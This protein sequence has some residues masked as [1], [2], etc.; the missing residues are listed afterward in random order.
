LFVLGIYV[1]TYMLGS[2]PA[3]TGQAPG[4]SLCSG[5]MWK[6]LHGTWGG[7][8]ALMHRRGDLTQCLGGG[9]AVMKAILF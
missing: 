4:H 3:L 7:G 8:G 6:T 5:G 1:C 9:R 2:L